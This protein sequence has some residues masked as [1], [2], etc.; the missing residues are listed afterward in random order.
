MAPAT[1]MVVDVDL[2]G[3]GNITAIT[4]IDAQQLAKE[5]LNQFSGVAQQQ[6]KQAV[7]I[8]RQGVGALAARMGKV[9]LG[10]TV[11]IWVAWFLLPAASINLGFL[12]SKSFTFWD[13]LG[14]DLSNPINMA[15]GSSHGV[16]AVI[17]LLAIA[18]PIAA[19]FVLHPR[20]NYLKAMP[21]AFLLL[22]V[23]KVWWTVNQAL[24]GT[25]QGARGE[26]ARFTSEM[27]ETAVKSMMEAISIGAGTYILVIAS[28]IL[29]L[30][31]FKRRASA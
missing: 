16:F 1:N 20:A 28:V 13:L 29:A 12:G 19:P 24:G 5:R 8:A 4:A 6:G 2:D 7:E 27:A 25:Q 9:A 17:G 23:L 22:T 31:A 18:A 15:A 21:L 10:A 30:Q 14:I 11:A 26:M 3:A